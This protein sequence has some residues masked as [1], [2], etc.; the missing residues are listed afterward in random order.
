MSARSAPEQSA[1]R[2]P[3]WASA[4]FGAALRRAVS[5][6]AFAGFALLVTLWILSGW[7][8][9]VAGIL[10]F[11]AVLVALPVTLRIVVRPT[12][13]PRW[14]VVVGAPVIG[15]AWAAAPGRYSDQSFAVIW[16][17][18]LLVVGAGFLLTRRLA[19]AAGG[20][21]GVLSGGSIQVFHPDW[22][23]QLAFDVAGTCIAIAIA[24]GAARLAIERF[25][26][27]ADRDE[28]KTE[29]ALRRA[30]AERAAVRRASEAARTLHDT[31]INTLGAVANGG[32]VMHDLERVQARCAADLEIIASI[33]DDDRTASEVDVPLPS[34][35][36]LGERAAVEVELIGLTEEEF[37]AWVVA[38]ER[39]VAAAVLE[40]S[41]EVLQN[42]ARHAGVQHAR[43]DLEYADGTSVLRIRDDGV[44]FEPELGIGRGLRESLIGRCA[45]VGVVATVTS[46]PGQG[47]TVTMLVPGSLR[48]EPTSEGSNLV[49]AA[50]TARGLAAWLWAGVA[51]AMV[52]A[53]ELMSRPDVYEPVWG[54]LPVLLA[55]LGGSFV[56][57]RRWQRLGLGLEILLI[58]SLILVWLLALAGA[59][60]GR[61]DVADW[62]A[63]VPSVPW[64]LLVYFGRP[65]AA[66]A[67]SAVFWATVS[68]VTTSQLLAG[69]PA[70]WSIATGS[71]VCY[72][73]VLGLSRF[74]DA[75]DTI[76][77]RAGDDARTT[78]ILREQAA[79]RT[80]SQQALARWKVAGLERSAELLEA[81]SQ[82]R[83]PPTQIELRRDCAAEERHLRQLLLLSPELVHLGVW[84]TRASAEAR[85]AGVEL[86]LR[87]GE[88]DAPDVAGA[89]WLGALVCR[90][91]EALGPGMPLTIGLYPSGAGG[92]QLLVVG[93]PEMADSPG[94]ID[95]A[96]PGWAIHLRRYAK[97]SV[98]EVH[99]P[100]SAIEPELRAQS[101]A[102]STAQSAGVIG[103]DR[104][105]H[106]DERRS[107]A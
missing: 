93:P 94:L 19:L 9:G 90:A 68:L 12:A 96:P 25:L 27:R 70:A 23:G 92:G 17:S 13:D 62:Q 74:R 59:E 51:T 16:I 2:S 20:V 103:P 8:A 47:V 40:A 79:V 61:G 95:R 91:V 99:W 65:G 26:A 75:F 76:G 86:A 77:A 6:P 71:G 33:L 18:Y 82:G 81:I 102:E 72:L 14:L 53:L 4:T 50:A 64:V 88:R 100:G 89:A 57:V 41:A 87:T 42:V 78:A 45:D 37:A 38:Q 35:R 48:A 56:A 106:R 11:G 10:L 63:L 52:P 101:A 43:V 29:A 46:R 30:A 55:V 1:G 31:V 5:V 32:R 69:A 85:A 24:V 39:P 58:V 44:G 3:G 97:Q 49:V 34:W 104:A 83:T 73:F 107:R 22:A 66:R 105:T 36:E 15:C 21:L 7:P 28:E 80:A 67:A 54:A 60:F 98:V 84:F